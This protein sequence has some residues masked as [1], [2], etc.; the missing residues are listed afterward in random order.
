MLR[1]IVTSSFLMI[2]CALP[3]AAR[4]HSWQSETEGIT[5][6]E[7]EQVIFALESMVTDAT[8]VNWALAAGRGDPVALF[9]TMVNSSPNLSVSP[10]HA[11]RVLL[12]F[13]ALR[14]GVVSSEGVY[15]DDADVFAWY[16]ILH[17]ADIPAVDSNRDRL[18]AWLQEIRIEALK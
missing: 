4:S 5:L 3:N 15:A 12:T 13:E 10:E 16:E 18:E 2:L 17:L 1:D 11:D 6:N 7:V 9:H 14:S 8:E